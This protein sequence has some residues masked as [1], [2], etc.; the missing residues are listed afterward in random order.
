MDPCTV[1]CCTGG[2]D[3]NYLFPKKPKVKKRNKI[4]I[5]TVW[6]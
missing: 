5:P 6:H 1:I 4:N 3:V 2:W